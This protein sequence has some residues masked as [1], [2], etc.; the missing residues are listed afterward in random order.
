VLPDRVIVLADIAESAEEI[1]AGRARTALANAEKQL[2]AAAGPE[3]EAAQQAITRARARL[4]VAAGGAHEG[5][6]A[7]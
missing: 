4:E 1:D 6:P 2:A 5:H 3:W 7:H